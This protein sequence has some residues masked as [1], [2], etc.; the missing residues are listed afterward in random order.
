MSSASRSH[1]KRQRRTHA[2]SGRASSSPIPSPPKEWPTCADSLQVDERH[3]QS[4]EALLE[5]IPRYD[6][7]VVRSETKVTAPTDRG[8][9]AA[10]HHRARGRRRG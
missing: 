3:G 2:A 1:P 4:A 10:A 9:R 7:L 5:I 6:A 8:G